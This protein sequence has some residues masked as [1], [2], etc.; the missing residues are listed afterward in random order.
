MINSRE[1]N[2]SQQGFTCSAQYQMSKTLQVTSRSGSCSG[3]QEAANESETPGSNKDSHGKMTHQHG[4]CPTT[5]FRGPYWSSTESP[6]KGHMRQELHCS[7]LILHPFAWHIAVWHGMR[8]NTLSLYRVDKAYGSGCQNGTEF[9]H[10][11]PMNC[12]Y[13]HRQ[14]ASLDEAIIHNTRC[15]IYSKK[16]KIRHALVL[17]LEK[18]IQL[19]HWV[20]THK[21]YH[22]SVASWQCQ[23]CC[24]V[25]TVAS[26]YSL[27]MLTFLTRSAVRRHKPW[28]CIRTSLIK[29][30]CQTEWWQLTSPL[31]AVG[32][33][34][35]W[36]W[37]TSP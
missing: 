16:W 7:L 27:E 32:E 34:D 17:C 13:S 37:E 30:S 8:P 14:H 21:E 29:R 36:L 26:F 28:F 2:N 31:I 23:Q 25:Y 15:K 4:N 33:F 20:F 18:V 1:C 22:L 24:W 11:F 10:E 6:C 35:L 5:C 3:E 9:F 12:I 19:S